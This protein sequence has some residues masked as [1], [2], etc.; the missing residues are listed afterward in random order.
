MSIDRLLTQ[1][2]TII[3]YPTG[4]ADEYGN[5]TRDDPDETDEPCRL[6]PE[7]THEDTDNRETAISSWVLFLRADADVTHIDEV[8]IDGALYQIDGEPAPIRTPAGLHHWEVPLQRVSDI[9][10]V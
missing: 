7:A 4:A 9:D 8:R 1:T 6:D 10:E 5:P 3:R 2:A